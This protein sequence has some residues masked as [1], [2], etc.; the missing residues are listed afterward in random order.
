MDRV[1]KFGVRR[2]GNVYP[3]DIVWIRHR[4]HSTRI[5]LAATTR[6]CAQ[7]TSC[8]RTPAVASGPHRPPQ[9]YGHTRGYAPRRGSKRR[10][11][12]VKVV[13]STA[14]RRH[15]RLSTKPIRGT[16]PGFG[17]TAKSRE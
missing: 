5:H 8:G 13:R 9:A 15:R 4:V 17:P 10:A 11:V 14:E 7:Q 16:F 2:R 6:G 3:W 12:N 1:A